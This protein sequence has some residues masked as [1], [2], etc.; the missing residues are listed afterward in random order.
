[1]E[2]F[3]DWLRKKVRNPRFRRGYEH[4]RLAVRLGHRIYQLREK[5]GLTQAQLARRM[6]TKQ[7]AIARLE[8]GDYEGFTMK[9]LQRIA[10]AT[11]TEL[12]I[13]FR[14]PAKRAAGH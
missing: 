9:T 12:V 2:Y 4:A 11:R 14:R 7:Q 1:M 8:R 10:Q 5:L 6:G 13:D 3:D